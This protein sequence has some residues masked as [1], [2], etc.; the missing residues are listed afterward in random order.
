MLT[1]APIRCPQGCESTYF[2]IESENR[3]IGK[4]PGESRSRRLGMSLLSLEGVHALYNHVIVVLKGITLRVGQG[5]IVVLLGANGAGKST[6]L[7]AV[8]NLLPAQRGQVSRGRI[9]R[10]R[11]HRH[12]ACR[13]GPHRRS[14]RRVC[15]C[16]EPRSSPAAAPPYLAQPLCRT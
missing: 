1:A 13:H 4:P 7:R 5:E 16:S 12:H 8:V 11:R 9:D 6:T 14:R 2:T 10:L 3:A 15:A